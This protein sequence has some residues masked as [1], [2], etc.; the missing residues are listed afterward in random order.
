MIKIRMLLKTCFISFGVS[1][2]IGISGLSIISCAK[3]NTQQKPS[4]ENF[5]K[6]ALSESAYNL[7][8]QIFD[9]SIYHWDVND[10]AVFA[11]YGKP[12]VSNDNTNSIIATIIIQNKSSTLQY[13]INFKISYIKQTF[14]DI[15]NWTP[16]QAR[17]IDQWSRFKVQALSITADA[18]L[19]LAKASN[20]W[21]TFKWTVGT[22]EQIVWQ[23]NESAEFDVF[24]NLNNGTDPYPGMQGQP[25]ANN[26][27]R[28]VSAIISIK[29]YTKAGNY[30]ANPIKAI[31]DNSDNQPYN[32]NNWKFS[33]DY[34][35]QSSDKYRSSF[36]QQVTL[37][38]KVNNKQPQLPSLPNWNAFCGNNWSNL[39][40]S[41]PAKIS[42]DHSV[43]ILAYLNAH[44]YPNITI[45]NYLSSYTDITIQNGIAGL[46]N[47]I[48][49]EFIANKR[50]Y[51][52]ILT[53]YFLFIPNSTNIGSSFNNIWDIQVVHK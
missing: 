34:Q 36:N 21:S 4:W 5:K 19:I 11:N 17:D 10:I 42:N 13:P 20:S 51:H 33:Q 25:T 37:A 8:K 50:N 23:P 52:L 44:Q 45:P 35:L 18:L 39:D 47:K 28:T 38:Q 41:V 2:L 49:F 30:D 1:S 32:K 24:G 7:Q 26:E 12:T 27:H 15:K 48:I 9:I 16:S 43:N 14:Y 40:N 53:T 29:N 22:V 3:K 31:I 46:E 6:A